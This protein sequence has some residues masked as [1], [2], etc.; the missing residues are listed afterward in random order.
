VSPRPEYSLTELRV[1]WYLKRHG[2]LTDSN[3]HD[4]RKPTIYGTLA[5]DLGI[6]VHTVRYAVAQLER[7]S[8]VLR[9][10]YGPKVASFSDGAGF[11]PLVR[12]E[13]V[14]RD[15]HLPSPPPPTPLAT[16]IARE[17]REL[18]ERV[19]PNHDPTVEQALLAVLDR[20]DELQKQLDRLR[21]IVDAQAKDNIVLREEVERLRRPPVKHVSEGLQ[22]RVRGALTEEQWEQLRH[23]PKD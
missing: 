16:V 23:S 20:N 5:A 14:D 12:L 1:L 10:F 18:Q 2:P 22:E 19:T 11:N 3:P 15:I 6:R 9:T 7:K 13:L 17:N 4:K 8:I 21:E